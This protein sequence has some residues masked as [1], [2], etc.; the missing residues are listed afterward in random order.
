MTIRVLIADDEALL[1]MAFSMILEAEPD[2]VPVGEAVDG[3]TAIRLAADLRPD[4]VLMDV[5][6]PGT[7][8]IEATR[9]ITRT[10]PQT[11]V[12][13]LTTFDLD[14]YAFAGLKAGASGFLLKNTR[15]QELLTAIRTVAAGNS[16]VSPRITHRLLEKFRP[17]IPDPTTTARDARLNRLSTREREVL[18]Q[19][20]SGLSNAEI[21]TTLNLAEATVKSHLGRILPKLELRDRIQAVI[22]AYETGLIH[23]A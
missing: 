17:H 20:A 12:L 6:M 18:I 1:R 16:V 22:F 11:K 19:V 23:P 14:E 13:I 2:L 8:G 9:E 3:A 7:D 5:R 15:P 10:C 4:V 21:A